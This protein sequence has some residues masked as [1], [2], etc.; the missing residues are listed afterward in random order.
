MKFFHELQRYAKLWADP[1]NSDPGEFIS[2]RNFLREKL[3]T[4][5][6]LTDGQKRRHI[7]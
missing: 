5:T 7:E 1:I 4:V 6:E 2:S 3:V